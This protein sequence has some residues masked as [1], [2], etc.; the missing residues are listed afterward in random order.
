MKEE[1]DQSLSVKME[2][3]GNQQPGS[4]AGSSAEVKKEEPWD[5]S[6][7]GGV[8]KEEEEDADF[9]DFKNGRNDQELIK[10]LRNQLK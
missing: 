8:K 1:S 6:A 7:T 5:N 4:Q 3:A 2:P 9:K 10:D